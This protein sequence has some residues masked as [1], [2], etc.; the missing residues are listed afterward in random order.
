MAGS[1]DSLVTAIRE[2]KL[3]FMWPSVFVVVLHSTPPPN[4]PVIKVACFL[5]L[6]YYT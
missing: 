2:L 6:H 1:N 3:D 5:M 4:K